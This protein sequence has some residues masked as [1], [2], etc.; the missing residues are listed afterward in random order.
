MILTSDQACKSIL[1]MMN[2][3]ADTVPE[4]RRDEAMEKIL[5]ALSGQM[6]QGP[7]HETEEK[8]E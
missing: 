4:E 2:K 7:V 6:F 8:P 1:E 3:W 5:N